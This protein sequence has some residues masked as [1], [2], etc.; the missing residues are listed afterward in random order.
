[1]RPGERLGSVHPVSS[2]CSSDFGY[3]ASHYS[4][5]SESARLL[6]HG[7]TAGRVRAVFAGVRA[8][9]PHDGGDFAQW[10]ASVGGLGPLCGRASPTPRR[11]L[12][13]GPGTG[14]V[15]R[16]LIAALGPDD[17]LD[18]VEL[19]ESFVARLRTC[20][21][22]RTPSF[23]WWPTACGCCTADGILPAEQGYHLIV[24]GLP[25]NNFAVAE[26]QQILAV[27]AGLLEPGGTLSFFEYIALRRLK[28][29]FAFGT[30]RA[31]LLGIGQVMGTLLG[32]H[33]VQCDRVWG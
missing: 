2:E 7:N 22:T 15:T 19:N 30:E 12:E 5:A 33:Q 31:R 3:P 8:E 4:T 16:H 18:L 21:A 25:L 28:A 23:G 1:M 29:R 14:A 6:T 32:Q 20:L 17:R 27:M 13:V 24:S 26:V 9:L 11:V 10:A